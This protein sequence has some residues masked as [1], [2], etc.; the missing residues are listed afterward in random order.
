MNVANH[1]HSLRVLIAQN[2]IVIAKLN[3][4]SDKSNLVSSRQHMELHYLKALSV[5]KDEVEHSLHH[6]LC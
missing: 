3:T 5:P 1:S 4:A 2:F 6:T